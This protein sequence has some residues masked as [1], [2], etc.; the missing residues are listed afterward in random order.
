MLIAYVIINANRHEGT[1]R[2]VWEVAERLSSSH[3]IHIWARTALL[4]KDSSIIWK[5]IP[6]PSRP[7][8][9]DFTS[10]RYLIDKELPKYRYD[11]IHSAG[12][13]TNLA[14]VYTIQTVHRCKMANLNPMRKLASVSP[15]RRLCWKMY[16]RA[17]LSAERAAYTCHGGNCKR[18]FLPV[19]EGTRNEFIAAYPELLSNDTLGSNVV[20]IPNGADLT[21]FNPKNRTVMRETI[22][23]N[24]GL[25]QE[26]FVLVFSG[27]DWRRKGLDI[28]FQAISL[29]DDNSVKL[30]VVGEDRSDKELRRL[31]C[32]MGIDSRIIFTG[33][34]TDVENYYAVGDLFVFPT[35]Y[36]AFSLATLEAAASGLPV[37]MTDVSGAKELIGDGLAGRLISR[38]PTVV[39]NAILSYRRSP[40]NLQEASLAARKRVESQFSWDVISD[41]TLKI[42]DRVLSLKFD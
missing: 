29:I 16:D 15:L 36:E 1:A 31:P 10:F 39:A 4:K 26:D 19:S 41:T 12:P 14:D 2:A 20:V 24:L 13:N 6:G 37:L 35:S 38:E 22:R 7:E 32:A 27:C 5:R 21:L 28:L 25:S 33:F 34:R 18:F 8:V 11:I 40:E 42:Y 23:K 17:V 3:E 30:L 9:A